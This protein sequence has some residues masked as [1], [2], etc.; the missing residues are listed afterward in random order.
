MPFIPQFPQP[1]A[2]LF[3]EKLGGIDHYWRVVYS[4]VQIKYGNSLFG[5]QL[6]QW[7]GQNRPVDEFGQR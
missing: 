5:T 3:E 4:A 7:P 2:D 1:I 6:P